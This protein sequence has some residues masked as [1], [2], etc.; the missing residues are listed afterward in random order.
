MHSFSPARRTV[1]N[2]PGKDLNSSGSLP[3]LSDRS[4]RQS[5]TEENENSIYG[6]FGKHSKSERS[7]PSQAAAAGVRAQQRTQNK[8]QMPVDLRPEGVSSER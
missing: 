3:P 4:I 6:A 2:R 7:M 1:P 8:A 5:Q